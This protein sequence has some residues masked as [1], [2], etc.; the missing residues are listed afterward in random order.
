MAEGRAVQ[1]AR[2][3]LGG[4]AVDAA[5]AGSGRTILFLGSGLW[6]ADD[7]AFVGPLAAIGQVTAP[8]HP[9][10]ATGEPPR[11]LASADDLSYVY[12]DLLDHLQARDVLLVGASLGGFVAAQ[13]AVKDCTRIA[14]MVLIGPLGL[15]PGKRDE[16]DYADVFATD[17]PDLVRLAFADAARFEVKPREIPE[18]ELTKRVRAREAL[19]RYV[20][21]PYM[22]DPRLHHKLHRARVPTLVLW[23]AAD[24]IARKACAEGYASAIPGARLQVIE[25]AGHLPHVERPDAVV[26]AIESFA[27]ALPGASAGKPAG[28]KGGR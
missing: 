24:R 7:A 1:T 22:H 26:A 17:E 18:A 15:R 2:F 19:S 3:E 23:G 10:Y 8:E 9:G 5:V 16:R 12:L 20:W 4:L 13:M 27:K 14:G 25:Q 28:R 6:L 21:Q 11:Q